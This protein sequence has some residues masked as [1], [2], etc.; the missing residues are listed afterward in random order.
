[1]YIFYGKIN[2]AEKIDLRCS[3]RVINNEK[4]RHSLH[5]QTKK[6]K[7]IPGPKIDTQNVLYRIINL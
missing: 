5:C 4:Q 7:V 2:T 1:V 3:V 6:N